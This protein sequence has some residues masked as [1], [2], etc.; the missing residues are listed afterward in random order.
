M[1]LYFCVTRTYPAL[2]SF[3]KL[4]AAVQLTQVWPA[5]PHCQLFPASHSFTELHK[6]SPSLTSQGTPV[7]T[8]APTDQQ[9]QSGQN[10]N[11]SHADLTTAHCQTTARATTEGPATAHQSAAMVAVCVSLGGNCAN[12][13]GWTF[14]GSCRTV[15]TRFPLPPSPLSPSAPPLFSP[16]STLSPAHL[17]PDRTGDLQRVRLTS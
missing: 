10:H 7:R 9:P 6:A 12:T 11:N 4:Q 14:N 5:L 16:P 13:V 8:T 2:P 17:G 1:V 3:T 15:S